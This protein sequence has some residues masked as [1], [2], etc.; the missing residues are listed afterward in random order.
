MRFESLS[1]MRTVIY[2]NYNKNDG[3]FNITEMK[4]RK[5]VFCFWVLC[6]ATSTGFFAY[7]Y[8]EAIRFDFGYLD[9]IEFI[10][11]RLDF[12]LKAMSL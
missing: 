3:S 8:Y 9:G 5:Y 12:N 2:K 6:L 10:N 1:A 4:V 11:G 7:H